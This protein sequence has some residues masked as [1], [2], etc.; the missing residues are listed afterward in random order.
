MRLPRLL[1][2]A[3][4]QVIAIVLAVGAAVVAAP[5]AIATQPVDL[6]DFAGTVRGVRSIEREGTATFAESG[7][8][9]T[10]TTESPAGSIGRVTLRYAIPTVDLTA[11]GSNG[12]F[13]LEFDSIVRSTGAS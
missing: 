7:G 2:S 4:A 8:K 9:A 6:D 5:A 13:F 12:Q 1:R 10:V 11:G 3:S